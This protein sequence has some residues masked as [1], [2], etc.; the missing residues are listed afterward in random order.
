MCPCCHSQTG[1]KSLLRAREARFRPVR[2]LANLLLLSAAV[3]LAGCGSRMS[4]PAQVRSKQTDII[5]E[6]SGKIAQTGKSLSAPAGSSVGQE[7][8]SFKVYGEGE[9]EGTGGLNTGATPSGERFQ[10]EAEESIAKESLKA[11]RR[12]LL[13]SQQDRLSDKQWQSVR[14]ADEKEAMSALSELS[15]RY[16]D[17]STV[18]FM[19]G[20]VKEHF[21]KKAQ[22]TEYYLQATEKNRHSSMYLFKLAK[23][24]ATAGN[25]SQAAA[26]WRQ[27][28]KM[29]PGCLPAKLGL[30]KSLL[31][32]NARSP[33]AIALL[34]EVLQAEPG[35][36]EASELLKKI[37]K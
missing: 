10:A 18:R 35:N 1:S 20:E 8:T 16:P 34:K 7:P 26:R 28:L 32:S 3:A 19:M 13:H 37:P 11:W 29:E 22:A 4:E 24:F 25:A 31:A 27:L 36:K 21:G 14:E 5:P 6:G 30:S 23:S 33:E 17:S 9:N 2:E 12:A 15:R